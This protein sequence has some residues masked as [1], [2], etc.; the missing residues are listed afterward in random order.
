MDPF[1]PDFADT[2]VS[3]MRPQFCYIPRDESLSPAVSI[4]TPYY[5]TGEIFLETARSVFQQ[6]L[7]QWEWLI[8]NDG[9]DDPEALQVL[10]LFREKDPRIRVI[11]LP[12]NRGLP[13]A[14]NKGIQEARSDLLFF[15]DSDD[16]IEPTAL[17]KMAWCLISY[18]ECGFCKGFTVGFGAQRYLSTIGFEAG[19]LFLERNPITVRAMV[20]RDVALFVKGFD[21]IMREGLEDWD[22]WLRCADKGFWGY[23]IPEYLDWYRRRPSHSD[24]WKAWTEEGIKRTRKELQRRYPRLYKEGI[25]QIT[26]RPLR[27]YESVP[28]EIPFTNL[29]AKN[30]TRILMIIP[31]M[32]MGGADKFNLDLVVQLQKRGY[33]ISIA[34]TLPGNYQ[35]YREFAALTPDIFILPHFLR[36]IDYPRFLYYLIRS[37][38]VDIVFISNSEIGYKLLP[39]LRSRCPEVTFVDFCHMEEEYWNNGGYPRLSVGYQELLDLTIVASQ[40]LKDWMVQRGAVPEGI[41]VCYINVDPEKFAP[42][43]DLRSKGR[44]KWGIPPEVPVILYAGRLCDQKQPKVFA[45]VMRELKSRGLHFRCLVAGDGEYKKWLSRYLW[46]HCLKKHVRLLGAVSN[47]EMRDLLAVSDIFFMPSKMEGIS[48]AIYEAMA[49]GVVPVSADVGGQRELVTPECGILIERS[50]ESEEVKA[51]ADALEKL[52]RS[53]E[54]RKSMGAEARKRVSTLFH[55]DQMGKRMDELLKRAQELHL[56]CPKPIPGKGLALEHTV[57]VLEYERLAQASRSLWKY[58]KIEAI[59]CR[60]FGFLSPWL[61]RLKR[62]VY[63]SLHPVQKAKDMVWI[64]GH[65]FKVFILSRRVQRQ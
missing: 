59:L 57:Q 48:L 62:V 23:T 22:F 37:R 31:W 41:E 33:E 26:P 35:W 14:R 61:A 16:L 60:L 54:L 38:Q 42:N 12:S 13:A 45:R 25:S 55:I 19:N 27:P 11:D 6:S 64:V 17:E 56:I 20:R 18:P 65:H 58:A 40:H 50:S 36:I 43:Q 3:P 47:R 39:Y 34:T 28:E 15:L 49:T 10:N 44:A 1:A 9:S 52:I 51:Y 46:R 24:R 53:P 30:K 32:A 63:L 4:I 5:N 29:L 8:I 21:E 7:Q 2:P